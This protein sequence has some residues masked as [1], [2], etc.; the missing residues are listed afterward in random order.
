MTS[1]LLPPQDHRAPATLRGDDP[2]LV[3][4]QRLPDFPVHRSVVIHV[5]GGLDAALRVAMMLRGRQYSVL[6]LAVDVR[7]GLA[8]SEVRATVVLAGPDTDL[9]L[10]RLRRLSVVVTAEKA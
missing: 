3:D 5:D 6:D 9:L 10:E 1:A 8:V 7:E 4:G 2:L